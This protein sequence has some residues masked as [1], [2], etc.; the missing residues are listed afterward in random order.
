VET[1]IDDGHQGADLDRLIRDRVTRKVSINSFHEQLPLP[2][3]RIIPSAGQTDPLG[4]PRPEVTYRIEDYVRR[5]A[6]HTRE[7][8]AEIAALLG[9]TE[10]EFNDDFAG[11]NHIM[12]TTIMGADPA[13]S[14]VDGDCR[15]HQ[16]PNLFVAGSSVF[17]TGGSIN[18]TLTLAALA[19]RLADHMVRTTRQG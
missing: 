7:A 14:V 19:L 10:V 6:E 16:H 1:L 15:T 13:T 17:P 11:N 18:S 3:N 12:G 4:L 2:E 9:G 5:S 8:Y